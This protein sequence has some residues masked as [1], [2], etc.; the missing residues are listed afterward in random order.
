MEL[1]KTT[2]K[3]A[4]P[5]GKIAYKMLAVSA[6]VFCRHSFGRRYAPTLLASFGFC[7]V[8]LSLFRTAMTQQAPA[9]IS[10]YLFIFL[11]LVLYHLARMWCSRVTI[12][13]YSNGQSWRFWERLPVNPRIV[14]MVIEP[15]T[16][17][18]VGWLLSSASNLLSVW[19]MTGGLCLF[20]KE[21][22]SHWQHGNR[23]LDSIDA[24]LEGERIGID[25][26]R[27][28]TPQGGGEQRVNPV[29]AVEQGQPPANNLQQIYGRL[30]PALQ[31]LV[32]PQN[33][34][35]PP[36]P[37]PNHPAN[38]PPATRQQVR[39]IGKRPNVPPVQ[40]NPPRRKYIA[41]LN[42]PQVPKPNPPNL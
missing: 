7:F 6:E 32:A 23:I 39:P 2:L 24:R 25:V 35:R 10:I 34:N 12:Q 4:L 41:P 29:A 22:L 20:V 27:Q 18:L 36:P 11:I 16:F 38:R 30:D 17:G 26:R 31:Q 33:R 19:I 14:K 42:P 8:F 28:T 21:C 40:R 3:W 15:L 1:I 9:F 37:A 13:S 5:S